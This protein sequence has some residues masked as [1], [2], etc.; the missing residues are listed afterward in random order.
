[1]RIGELA[2]LVGLSTRAIR[3]YH[4]RGLLPEPERRANG[5]R[6][7]GL[8]DVIVLARIRRLTELG[9][10][11][12]EVRDTLADDRG[13][14]LREMLTA[15]DADLA[16]QEAAIRARR[17]RLAAVLEQVGRHED[18][19]ISPEVADL[20]GELPTATGSIGAL[21]RELFTL[22]DMTPDS[23]QI[24]STLRAHVT[25]PATLALGQDLARQLEELAEAAVDDPRIA[26]LATRVAQSIPPGIVP[27]EVDLDHPFSAAVLESLA[28][29]QAEVFRRAMRQ[30][31]P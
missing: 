4:H 10:S 8:R 16:R 23:E 14:D 13:L 15:L 30:V 24:V 11:L 3:H 20:L 2:D 29:A 26:P 28:P 9:L 27:S 1:M 17:T 12:D 31:G 22:L 21:E 5:Y 19:T 6:E 18:A 7:Y 25:D